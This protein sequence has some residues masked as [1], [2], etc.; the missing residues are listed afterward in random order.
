MNIRNKLIFFTLAITFVS[1]CS[2]F[3][4][5]TAVD[6]NTIRMTQSG[7]VIGLDNGK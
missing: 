3:L 6:P 5:K 1:S 2:I 7:S 4:E